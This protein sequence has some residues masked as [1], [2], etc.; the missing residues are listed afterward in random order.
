MRDSFAIDPAT[1]WFS[2]GRGLAMPCMETWVISAALAPMR[3]II[4]E[5]AMPMMGDA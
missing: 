2:S 1:E 4:R 5:K 3:M